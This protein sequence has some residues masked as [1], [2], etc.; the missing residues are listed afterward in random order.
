MFMCH[1][2][3]NCI[4]TEQNDCVVIKVLSSTYLHLFIYF[5]YAYFQDFLMQI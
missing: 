5:V 1:G 2:L 3:S 4:E